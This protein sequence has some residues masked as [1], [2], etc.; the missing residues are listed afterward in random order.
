MLG[1][2]PDMED[3]SMNPDTPFDPGRWARLLGWGELNWRRGLDWL[4]GLLDDWPTALM[5]CACDDVPAIEYW[6]A[7]VQHLS[8]DCL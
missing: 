5:L 4:G 1:V 6:L 7:L 3:G 2:N 8:N